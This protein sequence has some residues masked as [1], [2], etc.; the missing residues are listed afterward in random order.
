MTINPSRLPFLLAIA[1]HGGVLAAADVLRVTPSAVSQQLSRLEDEV[2]R[3]LVERTPRGTTMTAAGR[4][5]VELAEN[6][7]RE[8][9]EAEQ[10][11]LAGDAD[12][13]GRVRIGGFQSFFRAVLA[14]SLPRWRSE[15]FHVEFDLREGT[16]TDL[17]RSLRAADLDVVVVEYDTAETVPALGTGIQEVPLM[18]DPWKLVVPSGTVAAGE[19][20]DLERLRV[21]WLGVEASAATFQAV[22]RVRTALRDSTSAH[23]YEEDATALA[24][25]S[26]GEGVTLLPGLALHGSLPEGVDVIDVPGLGARRL[27][28]RHRSNRREPSDA[29]RA[30]VAFLRDVSAA[31]QG[32]QTG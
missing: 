9:N 15:L 23:T 14:P 30:A 16:R 19:V 13:K 6:V 21:P 25:V 18:D 4:E 31:F 3:A 7:E 10:R 1:R 26:A 8:V 12:P 32:A 22:R 28:V 20:V 29:V 27:A 5:L 2:G 24:L 17:M 11:L